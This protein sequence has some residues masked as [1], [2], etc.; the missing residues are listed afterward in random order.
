MFLFVDR[1]TLAAS[2]PLSVGVDDGKVT[3]VKLTD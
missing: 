2:D 1:E 3:T